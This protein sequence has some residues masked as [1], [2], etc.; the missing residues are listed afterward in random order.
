MAADYKEYYI[1]PHI[2]NSRLTD[3]EEEEHFNFN[4]EFCSTTTE[5]KRGR[6][7]MM[8]LDWKIEEDYSKL[9]GR[10]GHRGECRHWTYKPA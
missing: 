9:K 7:K 6:L 2:S 4:S 1:K 8:L 10:A 5:Q 3:Q